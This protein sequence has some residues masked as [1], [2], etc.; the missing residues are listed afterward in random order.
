MSVMR[1]GKPYSHVVS[2]SDGAVQASTGRLFFNMC[3]M[4]PTVPAFLDHPFAS[5]TISEA[6]LPEDKWGSRRCHGMIAE[7]PT[8]QRITLSGKMV[9]VSGTADEAL[10]K[11]SLFSRHPEMKWWPA[12]HDFAFYELQIE[13]IFYINFY[14]GAKPMP[15]D[16]YF[17]SK[18]VQPW[19]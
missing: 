10:A 15:V 4:N 19:I 12:G 8:C 1:D 11:E 7:D 9:K 17:A 5:Y 6:N 16:K 18:P 14:G 13:D 2:L 3:E